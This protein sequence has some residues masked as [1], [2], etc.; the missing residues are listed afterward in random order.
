MQYA[1]MQSCLCFLYLYRQLRNLDTLHFVL[2]R[3][4]VST[5]LQR[6]IHAFLSVYIITTSLQYICIFLIHTGLFIVI[7]HLDIKRYFLRKGSTKFA[8]CNNATKNR[9]TYGK[10]V[11]LSVPRNIARIHLRKNFFWYAA[12]SFTAIRNIA[13]VSNIH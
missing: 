12:T 8:C 2:W 1:Q 11:S 7:T 3:R 10:L 9:L 5:I 13:L 6:Y 4:N